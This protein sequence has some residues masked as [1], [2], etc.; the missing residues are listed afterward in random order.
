MLPVKLF[1]TDAPTFIIDPIDGT[2]NF[3]HGFPAFVV[4]VALAVGRKVVFGVMYDV[5]RDDCYTAVLGNGAFLNHQRQLKVSPC[6]KLKES[7]IATAIGSCRD[8]DVLDIV[9]ANCRAVTE[10]SHGLRTT[11]SAAYNLITVAAGR[12]EAYFESGIHVWDM[13]AGMLIVTEAGGVIR[14][15]NKE[16]D[17]NMM[18]RRVLA[19][20]ND[21]VADALQALVKPI[22]T[23]AP[24]ED[25][26]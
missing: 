22:M 12:A 14:D 10:Q 5:S 9:F 19:C 11:G 26:E 16:L 1:L 15:I 2:T 18:S 25:A 13:A 20:C 23:F 7:L 21:D 8:A 3:V 6:K 17:F 24:D 4:S